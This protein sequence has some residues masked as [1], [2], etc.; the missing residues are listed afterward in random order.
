MKRIICLLI[1]VSSAVVLRAQNGNEPRA[2]TIS[3]ISVEKCEYCNEEVIKTQCG[4]IPNSQIYIPGPDIADAIKKLWKQGLY[5][6]VEIFVDE[7]SATEVALTIKVEARP[8]V[9]SVFGKGLKKSHSDDIEAKLYFLKAKVYTAEKKLEAERVIR[10]FYIEKGYND[11]VVTSDTSEMKNNSGLAG[12]RVDFV[13]TVAKGSKI[14]IHK[15]KIDGNQEFSD[16]RLKRKL[17]ELKEKRWYR[18][19]AKSKFSKKDME[20]AKTNL[21]A[22]YNTNGYR[23]AVVE[24]DTTY[25]YDEKTIDVELKVYEGNQYYIRNISW[26]G[27]LKYRT[28]SLQSI[29]GIEKGDVYN[30]DL[31]MNRIS[32]DFTGRDVSSLYLDDGYLFF[33][34]D[35]VEVRVVGDSV[36]L[37]MRIFEGPQAIIRNVWVEG[38]DKTSD[39]VILRELRTLPG[40]KFSRQDLI[41]SQRDILYLNYFNQETLQVIPIPDPVNGTVDLKYIV[42]EKPSDQL[43]VQGGWGGRVRDVNGNVVGGGFVGT[44]QVGFNNFSTRKIFQR[45]GWKPV[46]AG[47]GQKLNLSVQMNGSG[48]QQYSISFLEPWLGGKKPN[49]LGV[50]LYYTLNKSVAS[51]FRMSTT[52]GSIDFGTRMKWPDDFFKSYTSFNYKYYAIENG[53]RAFAFLGF[54]DG[55]INIFSL[56]QSIA[57]VSI[58][59]PLF[60][61]SG[62]DISFSVE[63][64]PPFSLFSNKDY[65]TIDNAD[66]FNLLEFHKWKFSAT[67]YHQITKNLIL[68]PRAFFGYLGNYNKDYGIPPFER[69]FMGGS[70]LNGFSFYGWEYMPLRGYPDQSVGP[71]DETG[72]ATGGNIFTKFTLEMR[73]PIMLNGPV[74]LW[75]VAFA[76]AGNTW[77][78]FKEFDPFTLKRSAGVGVRVMVPMVGLMGVDAGYGFDKPAPIGGG[79]KWQL[80]MVLGQEF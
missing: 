65:S 44:I 4:L 49:S 74:S 20:T 33:N 64:T 62:S 68:R 77:L 21:V 6:N 35:P 23:D 14:K 57:R 27:N 80:T 8:I 61:R 40:N 11:A 34:V 45:G 41:R 36:D 72:N 51:D 63:A 78:G 50:S 76:E 46:P 1:L 55:F 58:D 30:R 73:Y 66:K 15:I 16:Q 29:L 32:G 43:Q 70:G 13:Y 79:T 7:L 2:F 5:S 69:F 37:E 28:D 47:D 67:W 53:S 54:D 71:K 39:F 42:E 60:P 10:N 22:F 52:G 9:G 24:F 12:N 3:Y 59:A 48:W 18:V 25:A 17:K 75:T 38:N 19:W 26:V 56:K 31:L